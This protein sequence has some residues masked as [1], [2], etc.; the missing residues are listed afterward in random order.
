MY[1]GGSLLARAIHSLMRLVE[2]SWFGPS[3]LVRAM[4]RSMRWDLRRRCSG[5]EELGLESRSIAMQALGQE[6][7]GPEAVY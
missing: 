3:V 1:E 6:A 5:G 4:M 7:L 2:R